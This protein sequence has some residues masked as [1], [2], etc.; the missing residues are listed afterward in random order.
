MNINAKIKITGEI[1]TGPRLGRNL[2]IKFKG[3]AVSLYETSSI[4]YTNL[5]LVFSTLKAISQLTTALIINT[6]M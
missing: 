3:G 1:S 2:L 6:Q 4:E 5:L